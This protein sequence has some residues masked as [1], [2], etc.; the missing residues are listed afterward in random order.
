MNLGWKGF[1]FSSYTPDKSELI[2]YLASGT[3]REVFELNEVCLREEL[4]LLS[5]LARLLCC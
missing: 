3:F 1:R 5:S 4:C 2:N